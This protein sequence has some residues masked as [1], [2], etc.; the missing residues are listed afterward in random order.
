[1]MAEKTSLINRLSEIVQIQKNAL[2]RIERSQTALN[3]N[4]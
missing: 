2:E 4:D 3:E 1:V